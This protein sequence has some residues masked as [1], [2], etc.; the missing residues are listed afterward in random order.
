[1]RVV[2]ALY[3]EPG[4]VIVDATWGRG[5]FWRRLPH[6]DP[7]A[8]DLRIDGVDLRALPERDGSV[9]VLTID[10][11]YRLDES[12]PEGGA[13]D[14]RDRFGLDAHLPN[15][16]AGWF[17]LL[18]L[19][20]GGIAEAVRVLSPRGRLLVKCQDATSGGAFQPM[21]LRIMQLIE[22]SGLALLD[23][24][25]LYSGTGPGSGRWKQQFRARRAHSYLIVAARSPTW[26]PRAPHQRPRPLATGV[27]FE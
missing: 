12:S 8:H 26:K 11:P 5:G 18:D 24:L 13:V 25:V 1:M 3:L 14:F 17:A 21:Q 22:E 4:D 16:Q 9:D 23:V 2:E 19:Y 10:P 27:L 15:G 20:R 6:L 7:I